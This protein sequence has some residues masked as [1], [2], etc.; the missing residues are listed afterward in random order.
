[1]SIGVG[2]KEFFVVPPISRPFFI[3]KSPIPINIGTRLCDYL[4]QMKTFLQLQF[5]QLLQT[6]QGYA[7]CQHHIRGAKQ[8]SMKVTAME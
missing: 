1:L 2:D 4:E 6:L 5:T 3:K 8:R 7:V